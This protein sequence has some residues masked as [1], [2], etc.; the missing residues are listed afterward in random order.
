MLGALG[1]LAARVA[2]GAH[3]DHVSLLDVLHLRSDAD[4]L[5][6][7]LVAHYLRVRD[8]TPSSRCSVEIG[9]A[10]VAREVGRSGWSATGD[11]G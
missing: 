4:S 10:T 8:V 3:T 5:P 11:G 9:T 6:H 2:L 7:N 1:A